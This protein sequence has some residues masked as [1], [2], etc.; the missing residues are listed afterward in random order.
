MS[1]VE[2]RDLGEP[3]A[4]VDQQRGVVLATRSAWPGRSLPATSSSPAEAGRSMPDPWSD[5]AR[6]SFYHAAMARALES[7][8]RAGV[9]GQRVGQ[10]STDIGVFGARVMWDTLGR[11]HRPRGGRDGY[12]RNA[13]PGLCTSTWRVGIT[14]RRS[15][16]GRRPSRRAS[17]TRITNEPGKTTPN[18]TRTS[19]IVFGWRSTRANEVGRRFSRRPTLPPSRSATRSLPIIPSQL[20]LVCCASVAWS[21]PYPWS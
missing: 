11:R 12:H 13:F 21:T 4:V 20:H 15:C 9:P 3:D 10:S 5:T 6:A 17:G 7:D 14:S 2:V 16:R 18:T 1:R 8:D 19:S